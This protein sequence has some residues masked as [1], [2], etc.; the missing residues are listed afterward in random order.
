ME[1][2]NLFKAI[3]AFQN[4]VPVIHRGSSGYGYTY[5]NLGSIFKVIN[6]LLKKHGIGFTQL[7]NGDAL[8]TLIFH[9]ETGETIK[10]SVT[11]QQG[12]SLGKMNVYQV[13]GS[14]VTY[15]RRY[16]LAAALGL[17]TD[18]DT[19]AN[20]PKGPDTTEATDTLLRSTT[21][22]ELA[23]NWKRIG[24]EM[25]LTK[26]CQSVKESMKQK[27]TPASA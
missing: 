22:D 16:S 27:L 19:D 26:D 8:D 9:I 1:T 12:V 25:Q 6:P 20:E 14:A 4:E 21:L 10:S 24:K 3:A 13:L 11:I 5:A 2:K 23:A 15:Y 17:I 7:L 18:S